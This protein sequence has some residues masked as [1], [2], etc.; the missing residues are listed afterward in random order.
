MPRDPNTKERSDVQ[1][2]IHHRHCPWLGLGNPIRRRLGAC[3]CA[4]FSNYGGFEMTQVLID[5]A[6][7]EQLIHGV[8]MGFNF[9]YGDVFGVRSN[10]MTDALAEGYAALANAEQQVPQWLPIETAPQNEKVLLACYGGIVIGM[11]RHY[12]IHNAPKFTHW[13][14]LPTPPKEQP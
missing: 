11:W 14:P 9:D 6:T 3:S 10:D 12:R 1:R 7:L 13:M 8:E 2:N 5:R 4:R